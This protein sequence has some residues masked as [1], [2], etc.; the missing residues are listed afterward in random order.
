MNLNWNTCYCS[1]GGPSHG[2]LQQS[3]KCPSLSVWAFPVDQKHPCMHPHTHTHTPTHKQHDYVL[4]S[5]GSCHAFSKQESS[6]LKVAEVN[7]A[8]HHLAHTEAMAEVVEWIATVILLNSKLGKYEHKLIMG[9]IYL[10]AYKFTFIS[11]ITRIVKEYGL[12]KSSA[13]QPTFECNGVHV[14]LL[15]QA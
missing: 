11:L 3:L 10:Y 1:L 8:I 6:H 15:Y 13:Y 4:L 14:E 12:P 7:H 5:Q 2:I 9:S